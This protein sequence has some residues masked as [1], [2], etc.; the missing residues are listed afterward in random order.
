MPNI[1]DYRLSI[2]I[3]TSTTRKMCKNNLSAGK[4]FSKFFFRVGTAKGGIILGGG[5]YLGIWSPATNDNRSMSESKIYLPTYTTTTLLF[6]CR[7]GVYSFP[8]ICILFESRAGIA[9]MAS[10][11]SS[12]DQRRYPHSDLSPAAS[13]LPSRSASN[14]S[15]VQATFAR[16]PPSLRT[17]ASNNSMVCQVK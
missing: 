2:I 13:L 9:S 12:A 11:G 7:F 14:G 4:F 8:Y 5:C 16:G 15:S 3:Y 17:M 10:F 1:V 6:H